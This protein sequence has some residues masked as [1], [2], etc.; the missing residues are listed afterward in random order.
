MDGRLRRRPYRAI[1][2]SVPLDPDVK[3]QAVA[4][5]RERKSV[6]DTH[7][8]LERRGLKISRGAVGKLRRETLGAAPEIEAAQLAQEAAAAAPTAPPA[9]PTS[10]D[11]TDH[12]AELQRL[13]KA[14]E[15]GMAHAD[16]RVQLAAVGQRAKLLEQ[17]RELE[18]TTAAA[19]GPQVVY[20]FPERVELVRLETD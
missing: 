6:R 5:L 1:L 18:N 17:L 11:K 12:L 2:D 14:T 15:P 19:Q 7:A 4:L 8:E 10:P 3:R 13:L 16:A 20:Y 9:A